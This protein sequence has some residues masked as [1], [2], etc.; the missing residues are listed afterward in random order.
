V[1]RSL[2]S[3]RLPIACFGAALV[4]SFVYLV[5]S[6]TGISFFYDDWELLVRRPGWS[7]AALL[8]PFHEHLIGGP[9]VIYKTLQATFGMTSATPYYVVSMLFLTLAAALLFAFLRVRVGE[10][11]AFFAVLPVLF[12]GAAAEDFFWIFQICFF[13]SVAAGL[14]MLL[15]LDRGDRTGDRLATVLLVVSLACSG[16]GIPFAAAALVDVLLGPRP[17]WPRAYLVAVPLAL[18]AIWWIGWG[19]NAEHEVSLHN[20]IHLPGYLLDA[21]GAGFAALC[22]Q[23]VND[24]S[25]PG[26]APLVFRLLAIAVAVGIAAKIGRE[27]RLSRRLAVVLAVALGF[28]ML[29]GLDRG[30]GRSPIAERFQYPSVVFILL[31]VGEAL[32]GVRLPR[33]TV[34]AVGA[35]SLFAA[36]AGFSILQD[37]RP[38]WENFGI[39]TRAVLAGVELAGPAARPGFVISGQMVDASV[40][41]YRDA[42][43]SFGSPAFSEAELLASGVDAEAAADTEM[44]HAMGVHLGQPL[45]E[46]LLGPGR[47]CRGR[48]GVGE[49]SRGVLVGSER[50]TLTNR[51]PVR[52]AID[53]AR[54]GP[55]PGI[56]LGAVRAGYTR[57]LE[58]PRGASPRPWRLVVLN[59]GPVEICE[60]G[61][62]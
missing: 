56:R 18:Y 55:A 28:W 51:G 23:Q 35:L 40:A 45:R 52:A 32:R 62:R 36:I 34:V 50:V 57:T 13:G 7:P 17:R 15:A 38:N 49:R 5:A 48:D 58:L 42:V 3:R 61:S 2:E 1:P 33:A 14:G 12:L 59:N 31:V 4:A 21:A 30:T 9:A 16:V 22:G 54:F 11:L 46:P 19:H 8:E 44:A 20:L 24:P 47:H 25:D 26:H 53:V 41:R 29:A 27:R 10:W 43:G 6:G 37:E 39:Q 60:P